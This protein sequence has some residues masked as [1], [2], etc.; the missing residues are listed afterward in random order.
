M[1]LFVYRD[2]YYKEK[3]EKEREKKARSEGREYTPVYIENVEEE[4]AEIIGEKNRN[5][6][7]RTI[8]VTFHKTMARFDNKNGRCC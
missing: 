1:I 6:P 2:D 7:T 3:E 4:T 8:E 5:G